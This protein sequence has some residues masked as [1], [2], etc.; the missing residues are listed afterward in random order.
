M[1]S[2]ESVLGLFEAQVR[3]APDVVAVRCEDVVFTYGE[4]DARANRLARY[5]MALGVGVESR[6][7]LCLPRGVDMVAALLGVWKAG[8]AYVPVDP[9]YP[10][11]RVAYLL[12][13]SG[14][15]CVLAQRESAGR[16][17]AD[18][19]DVEVVWLDDAGVALDIDGLDASAPDAPRHA[20]GLA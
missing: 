8:A 5:L 19:S 17:L 10:A 14:A 1:V 2:G 9:E 4:L 13:D 6:V 12:A 7:A 11:E 3:R 20:D 15:G 18:V 16:L